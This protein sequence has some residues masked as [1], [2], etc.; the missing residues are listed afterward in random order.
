MS[1]VS[2]ASSSMP[3]LLLTPEQ[4]L[5]KKG[6][7]RTTNPTSSS[8]FVWLATAITVLLA[9]ASNVGFAYASVRK[10]EDLN[11]QMDARILMQNQQHQQLQHDRMMPTKSPIDNLFSMH[12]AR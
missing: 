7:S 2:H 3:L 12:N 4:M 1:D 11:Q 5:T 6:R 9:A 8:L 10:V